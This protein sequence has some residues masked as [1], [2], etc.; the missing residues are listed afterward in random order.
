MTNALYVDSLQL[1]DNCTNT[2]NAGNVTNIAFSNVVI[3][4]AQALLGGQQYSEKLNHKNGN[5]FRW[6]PTYAGYFSSTNLVYPPGVTN[7]F[8]LALALST[9]IDSNGNGIKNYLDPT[10]FF[11]PSQVNFNLTL[12]NRPPRQASLNF[13]VP[14]NATN[15]YVQFKTN[16]LSGSWENLTNFVLPV[17]Q[18]PSPA[19]N[20]FVFDSITNGTRFY[21]VVVQPWLTYPF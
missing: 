12:S 4:Y 18:I 17:G 14:P 6:V 3:Y 1:V 19:T 21:R 16:L 2:D 20:I 7:T 5:H 15:Y 11:V 8:N 9:D 10:P 13:Q